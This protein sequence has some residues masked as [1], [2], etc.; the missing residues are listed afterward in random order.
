MLALSWRLLLPAFMVAENV[1]WLPY[2]HFLL[3]CLPSNQSAN[4]VYLSGNHMLMN[5]DWTC[6]L[7]SGSPIS[8]YS[9]HGTICL[10]GDLG[11]WLAVASEI[12]DAW[13]YNN[14]IHTTCLSHYPLLRLSIKI[15]ELFT[16]NH[17]KT[18]VWLLSVTIPLPSPSWL[19]LKANCM[20]PVSLFDNYF[21]WHLFVS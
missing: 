11:M 14:D 3:L 18:K 12:W 2:R 6:L 9:G 1:G 21:A 20:K 19:V 16:S 8:E 7:I 17:R 13:H 15:S 10:K 4:F 5:F